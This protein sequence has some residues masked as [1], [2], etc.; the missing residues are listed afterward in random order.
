LS[1]PCTAG[2]IVQ[3]VLARH[4]DYAG[5][6][7]KRIGET[8]FHP[9][10]SRKQPVLAWYK[11]ARLQLKSDLDK[12]SGKTAILGLAVADRATGRELVR[13]GL[14]CCLLN[15]VTEGIEVFND[16]G[17]ARLA[18][19]PRASLSDS[20]SPI[21]LR[22]TDRAGLRGGL[23]PDGSRAV[24][25]GDDPKDIEIA[26][27]SV[28]NAVPI[29]HLHP[30][31]QVRMVRFSADG[32]R[33]VA[34]LRDGS[35]VRWRTNALDNAGE[36]VGPPIDGVVS[37]ALATNAR[38]AVI[39]LNR[40]GFVVIDLESNERA[41]VPTGNLP[42]TRISVSADGRWIATSSGQSGGLYERTGVTARLAQPFAVEHDI[43]ALECGAGMAV[44]SAGGMLTVHGEHEVPVPTQGAAERVAL[45]CDGSLLAWVGRDTLTLVQPETAVELA[46]LPLADDVVRT[47]FS[48]DGRRLLA[49]HTDGTM[50]VWDVGLEPPASRPPPA[51]FDSDI[52]DDDRDFLGRL[53]EVD[54]FASLIAAKAVQPPLSIGVFG[55]W[56]SGKSWFMGQLKRRVDQIAADTRASHARQADVSFYKHIA[57]VQ[58]NAWHYAETDVLS[59]LVDHVFNR[60]D[61]GEVT[62]DTF[63]TG[64]VVAQTELAQAGLDEKRK[65]IALNTAEVELDKLAESRKAQE[66]QRA[67]AAAAARRAVSADETMKTVLASAE[68]VLKDVGWGG[69][70]GAAN[71]LIVAI[72]AQRAELERA[73]AVLTPLVLGDDA[74]L[75]KR[76]RKALLWTC[77]IP[78]IALVAGAWLGS[79]NDA[80]L[81]AL[82]G[83]GA[84]LAALLGGVTRVVVAHTRWVHDRREALTES[85]REIEHRIDEELSPLDESI[86]KTR[87]QELAKAKEVTTKRK[88]LDNAL[89][90]VDD[91]RKELA[92][93]KQPDRVLEDLV[94]A[95]IESG[96]Y[97]SKLGVIALA[98]RDFEKVSDLIR[99]VNES[100]DVPSASPTIEQNV[101]VNRI[102]LYIDDLDRCEPDKVAKVLQAVHLLLAFPLFVVVVGVDPR[103]VGRALKKHYPELLD[104]EGVE[105]NDYLEKI[106][107]IPFW[108]QSLNDD[109]T[110]SMLR[111]LTGVPP[112]SDRRRPGYRP[113]ENVENEGSDSGGSSDG[114]SSG[115]PSRSARRAGP[116]SAQLA[117]SRELNPRGLLLE[118]HEVEAM[119]QL[120]PLLGRSPRSLKR[121]VNV[122]RLFKVREPDVLDFA[123]AD[124][125]DADYLIVLYLLAEV[126]G[127][128]DS[129]DDLFDAI[130]AADDGDTAVMKDVPEGWPQTAGAYKPWL[131]EVGR[132]SF[133][134]MISAADPAT[135]ARPVFPLKADYVGKIP[136]S[137]G[138]I[139]VHITVDGKKAIAYACDGDTV[140]V[141]LVGSAENGVVTLF[142]KDKTSRLEGRLQGS[143]VVGTLWIGQKK[144][145][146]TTAAVQPPAGL[147]VYQE[148]GV[149]SSWIID[150]NQAATG[151]QRQPDGSTSA[152]PNL[153][154]D[155]TAVINGRTVAAIRVEVDSDVV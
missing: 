63:E 30:P 41:E 153:S 115:G 116:D 145:D 83:V 48:L 139:T 3:Q 9:P 65:A 44:V 1:E 78:A 15:D 95:R 148:G 87:K 129:A 21:V 127:R 122:Y 101:N 18:T 55:D 28:E 141:W 64:I 140:E 16:R 61:L 36:V 51:R 67:S 94:D 68:S 33:I 105:P 84:F 71:E 23:A 150:A 38:C 24:G 120:S 58:F 5:G 4:G 35:I 6:R 32:S 40:P 53:R 52:A 98:R 121:F 11:D 147:Y 99:A 114:G 155:G 82:G 29:V 119:E 54:A 37:G 109:R 125:P 22:P 90:I 130:R 46:S 79:L 108:L 69:V 138:V 70:S 113:A 12:L 13:T 112:A 42:L 123:D 8:A 14:F 137:S 49:S 149:R 106:F 88:S 45:N 7:A 143:T 17:R 154:I 66:E 118:T 134:A 91:K 74:G 124:R 75:K 107:Q 47:T 62:T 76:R 81:A 151:V 111:G 89:Q 128:P 73:N 50:K 59:S 135:P 152:A 103:W 104:G 43:R 131:D 133:R 26:V 19:I 77:V 56:G 31:S 86:D 142:N 132:F 34:L 126:T 146:F 92:K 10:D 110:A 96:E 39:R 27:W 57:Q 60:L 102:V 144:W 97:A 20:T 117:K 2:D 80:S 93:K 85:Q 136:I 100:I 25:Y 72:S